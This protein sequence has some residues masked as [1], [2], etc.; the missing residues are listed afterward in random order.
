MGYT[1]DGP[2]KRIYL[3]LGTTT[4]DAQDLYSRYKDWVQISDNSKYPLAMSAIGGDQI[5]ITNTVAPYFFM[6]NGWK[7]NPQEASHVLNVT[8]TILVAGGTGSPFNVTAGAYNVSIRSTI[9]VRAEGVATGGTAIDFDDLMD[10]ESIEA[11]VTL[12]QAMKLILASLAGKL[13]GAAGTTITIRN[14][15]GDN[16]NR[17]VATVDASG[18][19]TAIT[20]DLDG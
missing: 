12:R 10:G 13:S 16:R 8:G 20:Y 6:E 11:G 17:I 7:I 18:N 19:R 1:F 5:D 15:V 14:A 4:L 2:A 9:P 3:T